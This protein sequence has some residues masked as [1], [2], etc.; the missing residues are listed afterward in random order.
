MVLCRAYS[1]QVGGIE[2]CKWDLVS[3]QLLL[4]ADALSF[5]LRYCLLRNV[6]NAPK[7]IPQEK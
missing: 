2:V 1:I 5:Y 6:T 3:S 4:E 7:E